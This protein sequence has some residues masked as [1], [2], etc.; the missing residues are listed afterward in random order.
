[1]KRECNEKNLIKRL[2]VETLDRL[3]S[4]S[5]TTDILDLQE[6]CSGSNWIFGVLGFSDLF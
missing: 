4:G 1:M 6:R 3:D 5:P 2:T